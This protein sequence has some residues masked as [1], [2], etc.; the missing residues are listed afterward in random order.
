VLPDKDHFDVLPY[1]KPVQVAEHRRDM[2]T[3]PGAHHVKIIINAKIT[4]SQHNV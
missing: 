3:S 1:G 4:E 2:I